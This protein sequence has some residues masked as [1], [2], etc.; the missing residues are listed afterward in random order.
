MES[1]YQP[2]CGLTLAIMMK[3]TSEDMPEGPEIETIRRGLELGIVGQKI[4][5]V[6]VV[7]GGSF[8]VGPGGWW[9]QG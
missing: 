8:P 3:V 9:V 6:E 1:H 4:A 5:A 7:F 2:V